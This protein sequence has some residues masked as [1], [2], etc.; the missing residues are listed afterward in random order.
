MAHNDLSLAVLED[1]L[2]AAGHRRSA[3]FHGAKPFIGV[4]SVPFE[5]TARGRFFPSRNAILIA[6]G[7]DEDVAT[8][9]ELGHWLSY[10]HECGGTR[11]RHR[12]KCGYNGSHGSRFYRYAARAYREAGISP[13]RAVAFEHS[14][15]YKPPASWA[16]K[17]A[18]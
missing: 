3:T 14:C 5:S 12:T 13:E 1:A 17:T 4:V 6:A 10:C 2:A 7:P 18:W 16:R 8:A 11:Q 15:G 9:H